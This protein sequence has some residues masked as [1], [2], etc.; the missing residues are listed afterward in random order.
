MIEIQTRRGPVTKS[1]KWFCSQP[2]RSDAFR[3]VQY[4]QCQHI[5]PI[6]GFH[7]MDFHTIVVELSDSEDM[8]LGN[9]GKN[10]R[11]KINRARR[12][13]VCFALEKNLQNFA[14]FFNTFA[15]QKS[16][17]N[18]QEAQIDALAPHLHVTKAQL[19]GEV[20]V[21]H[22]YLIDT[23]TRRARLLH[24]ASHFRQENETIS[25]NLIGR[26][27]RF[28]HF[29]DILYFKN[30]GY[31]I[32]DFGGY[33]INTMQKELQQINK[34]KEGFGRTIIKESHYLSAPLYCLRML[35]KN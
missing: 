1:T 33:A 15:Q 5:E 13:G 19:D 2:D 31:K 27:N 10:T 4:N 30:L 23:I 24:S 12:E 32:Y 7:R 17:T 9:C 18:L 6:R 14:T 25:R 21:M 3:L 8:L 20:L 28:L 34:F 29:E 22:S 26:A 11:Y 35:Y 16:L